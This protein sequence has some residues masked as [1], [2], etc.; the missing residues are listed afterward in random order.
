MHTRAAG[1]ALHVKK[2]WF[3]YELY[4][5]KQ[6]LGFIWAFAYHETPLPLAKTIFIFFSNSGA[7]V[8]VSAFYNKQ[9]N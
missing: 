2:Q 5:Q 1:L 6:R 9:V 3:I 4:S 7:F 8:S